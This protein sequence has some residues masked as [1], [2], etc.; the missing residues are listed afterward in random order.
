MLTRV[1][2]KR[3]RGYKDFTTPLQPFSVIVGPN[4]AGKSTLIA[5]LRSGALMLSHAKRFNPTEDQSVQ[6]AKYKCHR[7]G[8][9]AFFVDD[10]T[11]RHDFARDRQTSVELEFEGK[12][13]LK[14]IWPSN[15]SNGFFYLSVDG[16]QPIDLSRTRQIFPTIG[17]L[18]GL[19]PVDPREKLLD[20]TYVKKNLGGRLSSMRFR[21]QLLT[22][23]GGR[24]DFKDFQQYC[25]KWL[26]EIKLQKPRVR[27]DEVD[28]FFKE[29]RW[30]RE[31]SWAGDGV[32]V[33]LQ[34]LL[35]V[36]RLTDSE[37]LV[38]DE[39]ELYLHPDLQRRLVELLKE[40]SIQCVLA[41]HSPEIISASPPESVLWVDRSQKRAIR[42]PENETLDQL[43]ES[44]GTGF[45]LRLARLMRTKVAFFVEGE[46][47]KYLKP[48]AKTLELRSLIIEVGVA[49]VPLHGSGNYKKLESFD[50]IAQNFLK[51]AIS[52]YVLF[53]RDFLSRETMRERVELLTNAGLQV[54]FWEHHE[55]ESYL[56]VPSAIA[57]LSGLD[58]ST[59]N[60]DLDSV[61]DE[62]KANVE[63][64]MLNS[65]FIEGP[66]GLMP[67][68]YLPQC[69][70][71]IAEY[72]DDPV[73]RL[74]R[75]PAKEILAGLN[76]KL[77]FSRTQC[78]VLHGACKNTERP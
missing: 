25:D 68:D 47:L 7:I 69:Q 40:T 27:D 58:E 33:F 55:L 29:G 56:I 31:I 6:K 17:V 23:E 41:T 54:H 74:K 72:W 2:L 20:S 78:G 4:N 5:A 42:S 21:N 60:E 18:P 73:E 16:G 14:A 67:G 46:D 13:S 39:P 44:I 28:V 19:R 9:G 51:G 32:Q 71:E 35:N 66:R 59:I 10:E 11:L 64:G 38:L 61:T 52:G 45:N 75:C 50:W 57:R 22:L 63:V 30:E 43:T 49:V 77:Q 15:E 3:F 62:M 1:T 53:D 65:R 36:F 8:S 70:A 37:T 12:A 48:L 76:A 26:P 24:P 34:V